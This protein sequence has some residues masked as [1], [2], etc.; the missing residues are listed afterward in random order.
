MADL[1]REG[2]RQRL[3]D[4]YLSGGMENAPD[5]N[6]LELFLSIV[7]PRR[8]VKPLTYDL[9]NK[10]GSLEGVINASPQDLMT[11]NGVGESTA[12]AITLVKKLNDKVVKNRNLNTT[13]IIGLVGASE[14]CINELS[15]EVVEV[16]IQFTLRND[17][18]II[19]KYV[20]SKGCVN[21]T[22]TDSRM[23]INNALRDNAAYVLLAHNHPNGSTSPSGEDVDFT[24]RMFRML[25]DMKISLID[26]L[27]VAGNSC[28]PII[29]N[30]MFEKYFNDTDKYFFK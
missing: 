12:V 13:K 9:I 5:H 18:S 3:R 10:F 30:K 23:I 29:H 22:N 2:H 16:L 7:I 11:V 17:G 14:Y 21:G 19:N 1:G 15:N 8:D 6:L 26:H 27:I 20:I 24:F 25:R 28:E 4:S